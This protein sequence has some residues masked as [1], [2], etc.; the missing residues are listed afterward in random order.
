MFATF[1]EHRATGRDHTVPRT[2]HQAAGLRAWQTPAPALLHAHVWLLAVHGGGKLDGSSPE[3]PVL[4]EAYPR[5]SA[6]SV[7]LQGGTPPSTESRL[8][9]QPA[10]TSAT[11]RCHCKQQQLMINLSGGASAVVVVK[12][13]TSTLA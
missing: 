10:S 11:T 1:G 7:P 6:T 5:S 3:M 4:V 2:A 13:F 12:V 9:R 8:S